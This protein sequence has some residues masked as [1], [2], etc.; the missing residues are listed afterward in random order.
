MV[1]QSPL[2]TV[3]PFTAPLIA[4][5]PM[6]ATDSLFKLHGVILNRKKVRLIQAAGMELQI[7]HAQSVSLIYLPR[8]VSTI[9]VSVNFEK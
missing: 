9:I 3:I 7:T 1:S 5:H 4:F 8:I 6:T 2:F